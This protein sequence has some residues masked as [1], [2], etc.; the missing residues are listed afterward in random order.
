MQM[1]EIV[2]TLSAAKAPKKEGKGNRD[3]DVIT[4]HMPLLG[5][6]ENGIKEG[7]YVSILFIGDMEVERKSL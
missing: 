2:Q 5:C 3:V 4:H 6:D 1:Q 7:V